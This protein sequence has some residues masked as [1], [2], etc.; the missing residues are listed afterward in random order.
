MEVAVIG[1]GNWGKNIVRTLQNNKH[2]GAVVDIDSELRRALAQEYPKLALFEDYKDVLKTDIPVVAIS[3]PAPTHF[4]IAKDAL[5]AGKDVFVEKPMSLLT[6][7]A[8]E[9]CAIAKKTKQILMVGHLLLYQPAITW[10]K[11]YVDSGALGDIYS[12]HQERLQ[13]GGAEPVENALWSLGVHDISVLNYLIPS[14]IVGIQVSGQR[15]LRPMIE[16]DVY[17][18]T[19]YAC[20]VKA[21]L[22]TS[23]LWPQKK[24]ILMI[25]GSKGILIFDELRQ[26]VT[27]HRKGMDKALRSWDEGSQVVFE[28]HSA[29][30][31]LELEHFLACVKRRSQPLSNGESGLNVIQ[32]LETASRVLERNSHPFRV[33]NTQ[34]PSRRI[35]TPRRTQTLHS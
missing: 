10:L 12:V 23:W 31:R 34:T 1:A 9:L 20:G 17:L 14:P 24:R 2:L 28:G 25:I 19:S 6:L 30:L 33:I 35:P 11:R 29:P 15:I 32:T 26:K 16:D 21:H 5:L 8:K 7:E 3:T 18:Y 27:L 13:F 4:Q 22:H